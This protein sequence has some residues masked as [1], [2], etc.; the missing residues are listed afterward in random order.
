MVGAGAVNAHDAA[1]TI[2]LKLLGDVEPVLG[3]STPQSRADNVVCVQGLRN[4]EGK[5]IIF[6][7]EYPST[8]IVRYTPAPAE[9]SSSETAPQGPCF[10]RQLSLRV[11]TGYPESMPAYFRQIA[12]DQTV[13][14]QSQVHLPLP[15]HMPALPD[16]S[17][18]QLA[19]LAVRV[20][21][22]QHTVRGLPQQIVARTM[23][24]I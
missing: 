4:H 24:G 21:H 19:V 16:C 20:E 17:Q 2:A 15:P 14:E 23:R 22:L 9:G 8:L 6:D 7:S 3:W 10:D 5:T 11:D 12:P 18:L 13:Q 1:A